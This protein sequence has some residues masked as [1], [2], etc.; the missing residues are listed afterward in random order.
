MNLP[1]F[2]TQWPSDEIVL[3]GHRITLYHVMKRHRA[4]MSPEQIVEDLWQRMGGC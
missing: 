1:D 4:G 3:T 2:L